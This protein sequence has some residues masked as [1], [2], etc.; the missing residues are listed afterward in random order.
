MLYMDRP[1][2]AGFSF[3]RSGNYSA[4][5]NDWQTAKDSVALLEVRQYNCTHALTAWGRG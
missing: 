2:G 3:S 1:A 5:A 4:F